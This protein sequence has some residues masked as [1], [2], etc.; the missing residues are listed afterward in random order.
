MFKI[1]LASV[2]GKH[3]PLLYQ[4]KSSDRALISG[5]VYIVGLKV[6]SIMWSKASFWGSFYARLLLRGIA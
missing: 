6:L 3:L 1:R 5:F 4:T 2:R